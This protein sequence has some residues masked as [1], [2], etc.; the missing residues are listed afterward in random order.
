MHRKTAINRGNVSDQSER[1]DTRHGA[2]TVGIFIHLQYLYSTDHPGRDD[3]RTHTNAI[4]ILLLANNRAV[5]GNT[6]HRCLWVKLTL[7]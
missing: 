4:S 1:V 3:A 2:I 7:A 5:N 6:W